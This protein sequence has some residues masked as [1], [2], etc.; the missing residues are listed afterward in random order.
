MNPTSPQKYETTR[1]RMVRGKTR[2]SD[3]AIDDVAGILE[4][5][6]DDELKK[7]EID[8]IAKD[9]PW[10]DERKGKIWREEVRRPLEGYPELLGLYRSCFDD[11]A[12]RPYIEIYPN[13]IKSVSGVKS[14]ANGRFKFAMAVVIAHELA[15]ALMDTPPDE[16]KEESDDDDLCEYM[17]KMFCSLHEKEYRDGRWYKIVEESLANWIVYQ[18]R[19]SDS[20]R[21]EVEAFI[22]RQPPE[23]RRAF[24]WRHLTKPAY[25]TARIWKRIKELYAWRFEAVKS[26]LDNTECLQSLYPAAKK[27]ERGD[28][29]GLI[30][31]FDALTQELEWHLTFKLMAKKRVLR[32]YKLLDTTEEPTWA[33]Q[34]LV[35]LSEM[36]FI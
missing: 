23:Y 29:D 30:E 35:N 32:L 21:A 31:G 3:K 9:K 4:R 33:V 27:I 1:F 10:D 15:H 18:Q 8:V 6:L 25:E 19:W 13:R 17:A 22:K 20:E 2:L 24:Q 11:V 26:Y 7:I 36:I 16:Y 14:Y 34:G 5:V 28:A 12:Q